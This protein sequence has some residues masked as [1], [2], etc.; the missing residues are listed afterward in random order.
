MIDISATRIQDSEAVKAEKDQVNDDVQAKDY[1]VNFA[2]A[3]TPHW[4]RQEITKVHHGVE[5]QDNDHFIEG[6]KAVGEWRLHW[7]KPQ[8]CD[9]HAR[10]ERVLY[11][12]LAKYKPLQT[13]KCHTESHPAGKEHHLKYQNLLDVF[14]LRILETCKEGTILFLEVEV[15]GPFRPISAVVY[16]EDNRHEYSEEEENVS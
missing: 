6:G 14:L 9:D 1:D 12:Q 3:V 2:E 10:R 13:H 16:K 15:S 11:G 4:V 5:E 8:H 7:L